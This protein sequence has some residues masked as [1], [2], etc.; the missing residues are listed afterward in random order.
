M[1]LLK[2]ISLAAFEE[3]DCT[4]KCYLSSLTRLNDVQLL[5]VALS[6]SAAKEQDHK[7]NKQVN[8]C[9]NVVQNQDRKWMND[10]QINLFRE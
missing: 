4:H 3:S 5:M 2:T 9:A 8:Y 6:Y 1:I 7:K 10:N